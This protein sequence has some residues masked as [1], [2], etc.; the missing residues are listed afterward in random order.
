M[1]VMGLVGYV[2]RK[3]DLEAAPI[4]IGLVLAPILEISMRQS[5]ILSKGS[6]AIFLQ[7][8]IAGSLLGVALAL[9]ALAL[10]SLV[11]RLARW[12]ERPVRPGKVG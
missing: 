7:R 12:R 4:V 11:R 1:T 2:L 3:F 8:P 5:L 9:V 10:I 6:Y